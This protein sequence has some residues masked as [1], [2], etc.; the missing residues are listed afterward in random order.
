[1]R[2]LPAFLFIL[3]S[4]ISGLAADAATPATPSF[5]PAPSNTFTTFQKVSIDDATP[6]VAIYYTTNG[7]APT[8][9]SARYT[10]PV[11]LT[12]TTK[13]RAIAVADGVVSSVYTATYTINPADAP[14]FNVAAGTYTTK[15][16]V[17]ISD[18]TPGAVI[19]YTTNGLAPT[20]S[21][22]VYTQPVTITSTTTLRA[23]AALSDGPPSPIMTAIYTLTPAKAPTFSLAGGSFSTTQTVSISDATAGAT[24]YYTTSGL[25]PTTSSTVYTGPVKLPTTT[26]L[27]AVAAIAGGPASGITTD[28]YTIVPAAAPVF[29][30]AGGTYASKQT[31]SISDATPGAIIYYTTNGLAPTTSSSVYSQPIT[32]TSTTKLRAVAALTNGPASSVT[33]V[34][35]AISATTPDAPTFSLPAG[36]YATKQTVSISESTTGAKVYYTTNG[37][38]PT[39]SSSVYTAPLAL[40]A[41]TTLRAI[42]AV[43]NGSS[44]SVM[45]ATYSFTSAVAAVPTFSLAGG[46]YNTFQKVSISDATPGAIIYYTT[47]GLAPTTSSAVYSGPL[48]LTST[49]KLRAIA[50]VSGGTASAVLTVTYTI[51]PAATPTF[52]LPAGSYTGTQLITISDATPGA[53]IYYTTNGVAPT[54]ASAVYTAPVSIGANT[55]LR[56]VAIYPGG[57]SSATETAIYTITQSPTPVH[58]INTSGSF[59]GFSINY[60]GAGTAWPQMPVGVI[61]VWNSGANWGELNP[62][63]GT[64]QWN[65]LDQQINDAKANDSEI[66]YTFGEVPAWAL[67]SKVEIESI[68]RSNG[69][70]TV[71][72]SQPHL[73]YYNSSQPA[74]SQIQVTIAGVSDSSFNGSFYLTGVPNATTFTYAQAG[75]TASASSGT[76][77]TVCSGPY[78]PSACAEPPSSLTY[79]DQFVTAIASHVGTGAIQYWELWNE[80]NV[81]SFWKGDPKLLVSMAEDARKII[82]SVDSNALI[83]T[84]GVTGNY[85][86]A[87]ECNG[88]PSYCGS[89]WLSNWLSLGGSDLVDGAAFHGYPVIGSAPEQIQGAVDLLHATMSQYGLGSAPLVDTESSWS[90]DSSMTATT[91]QQS[92][93]ARHLI[94]EQSMG[95]QRTLWYA[96]DSPTWG[97]LWSSAGGLNSAGS[98]YGEIEKWLTGVTVT[99]PC[100][101]AADLSTFTCEYTRAD[102]YKAEAIWNAKGAV[103]VPVPSQYIQYRDVNG[104]VHSVSGGT[105]DISTTPILLETSSVF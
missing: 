92:W 9:S 51:E 83:L 77:S 102:G 10:G 61:R 29:S 68:S 21:S 22:A 52:S 67:A 101:L 59:F 81:P 79:W 75:S 17:T 3:V 86:T 72:T 91:D 57:P 105:V 12:S 24:I 15:R 4:M 93:L 56:A 26:T 19:Y 89:A 36:T 32:V 30:L 35:Y 63:S 34:D 14:T 98:T 73:F 44:S 95:V 62:A 80:P 54:A 94:L 82:K 16:T 78:A 66:V 6:G 53:V 97:T 11:L 84:P 74:T 5:S 38:T 2:R 20:T 27:R 100:S 8:T 104:L 103:S 90:T 69:V 18:Q 48:T 7:L 46:T 49:T 1:M 64:Y 23:I 99:Q 43:S 65:R 41:N 47:N 55:T 88:Y 31:V 42:A 37:T 60:L 25:A 96:Y 50:A 28:V 58:S 85:E 71:T 40:T 87:E 33:T 13:L 70:V 76:Y 39:T 45:S